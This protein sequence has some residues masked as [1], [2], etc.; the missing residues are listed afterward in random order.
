MAK[1]FIGLLALTFCHTE[2]VVSVV[3]FD[4][5]QE[6]SGMRVDKGLHPHL[7]PAAAHPYARFK[8]PK[9]ATT[10]VA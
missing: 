3:P 7:F 1:N 10:P 2:E 5:I 9:P 4:R 8:A 6:A